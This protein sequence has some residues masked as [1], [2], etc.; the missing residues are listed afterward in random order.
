MRVLILHPNFPAQYRHIATALGSDPEN[1]VIFG[2]RNERPEW[3]IPGVRKILFTPSRE[4]RPETHHYVRPLESAVLCGQAVYRVAEKLKA[5]GFIPD[6]VCGHSGWGPTLFI[7]D[8]FPKTK[9]LCYFEWFYNAFGSDANFDPADPLS[10]DDIPRI[11][12]KNSSILID[13]YS[14]DWGVSPTN[15]QKSQ[16]PK[17]FHSKITVLHDGVDTEYFK[18]NPGAKLVLPNLDLS[19]VD[20]IVTYVARGMEPYRGFPEFIESI[21]YIQERRPN[22]HVVIVGSDRVCYGKSLPNGKTYKQ[23]MLEK[24]PLDM[25]RVHFVG[26][27]PYGLYLKVIQASSAH[28]YLTRP[29]VLSWSMIECMSTGCLVI[30]SDTA[31]VTEVI[32]DGENGLLVDFFS[33]KQ[34]AA[35]VDEVLNHPTRMAEIRAKARETVLER[36][37][38]SDLLPRHLQLIKDVASGNLPDEKKQPEKPSKPKKASKGFQVLKQK[39]GKS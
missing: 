25:S 8:I 36:Y 29:F 6:I 3:V 7:K 30:G 39:A 32:R 18:P 23:E 20:E 15:W 16:F 27:L 28:V 2:T 10:P 13:L 4:P 37:A 9:L 11:R 34:I 12:V 17:E 21:A 22:C 19:G 1:Q 26:S 24:V 33:P 14:C 31:P 38:L 35:R 5:E